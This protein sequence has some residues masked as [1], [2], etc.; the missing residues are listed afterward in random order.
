[1]K[2]LKIF[3][4]PDREEQEQERDEIAEA[5]NQLQTGEFQLLQLAYYDWHGEDLPEEELDA[6][7][8]DYMIRKQVPAWARHYARRIIDGIAEERIDANSAAFHRYDPNYI[9]YVPDG[10]RRFVW[11]CLCCGA[12]IVGGLAI[13]TFAAEEPASLLPPY[14]ERAEVSQDR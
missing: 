11:A 2:F 9:T 4:E 10:V 14:F 1:M 5:A 6:L 12:V 3:F 7:F 13:A 8:A